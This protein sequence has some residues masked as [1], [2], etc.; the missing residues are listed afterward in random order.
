M[1]KSKP[2][3]KEKM[4]T[5]SPTLVTN[6]RDITIPN[7][8]LPP[9]LF[10]TDRFPSKRLNIY[11]SPE[12]MAFIRNVLRDMPEF[13]TIQNS[14]FGKLFDLPTRQ[15]P[16]SCKLIHSL[17]TR[18]LICLPKNTLW[19]VFGGNPFQYGLEEFGTITGL[20][21]RSFS[22]DYHPDTVKL[23][24]KPNMS[25]WKK[26]R[27]ALI[28]IV[29]GVLIAH[30]QVPCPTPCYVRM[31]EDLPS[32]LNFPW[33][34]ES[35]LK[36]ITCMRP[37]NLLP[38]K[39]DDPVKTL[40]W[41]LK[42]RTFR[43]QA[44]F[45]DLRIMD[46][47][48]GYLV[49]H[50]SINY[51]GIIRIELDS[52]LHVTP[53]IPTQSQPQPGWGMWP[54]DPKKDSV[55]NM[56]QLIT[57]QQP[58]SKPMWPGGDTSEH[59]IVKPK[60]AKKLLVKKMSCSLKES[61]K[62]NKVK[63]LQQVIKR[64]KKHSHGRHSS[65]N[66]LISRRKKQ[67]S[68][69]HCSESVTIVP[70][71]DGEQNKQEPIPMETEEFPFSQSPIISQYA[72]Q[73][74]GQAADQPPV[75]SL[76][77]H[78]SSIHVSPIHNSPIHTNKPAETTSPAQTPPLKSNDSLSG[79]A[80]HAS[81]VNAFTATASS[82]SPPG[83]NGCTVTS[84][85]PAHEAQVVD[86][87]GSFPAKRHVPSTVEIHLAK[88]LSRSP[89]IPALSLI[90][91]F[92][93]LQW[94]VFFK[95]LSASENIFHSTHST[96]EFSNNF[97]LD[98]AD[99]KKGTTTYVSRAFVI[100]FLF[101]SFFM[102]NMTHIPSSQQVE[103]LI[104]MLAARHSNLLAREYFAFMTPYLS[105]CIQ[106]KWRKFK[107]ARKKELFQW[108]QRLVD[109]V[110]LPGKKWM[111]DIHTVCTTMIWNN[112][113]WV[114]LAINLDMGYVEI[115]D[116]LPSLFANR[117]VDRFMESIVTTFPYLVKQVAKC[118]QTQFGGLKPFLWRRIPDIYTNSRSGDCGPVS[119]KFLEMHAQGDTPPHV[120]HHQPNCLRLPQAIRHGHLQDNRATLLPS[121]IPTSHSSSH[122]R[123]VYA[124]C[125]FCC[126]FKSKMTLSVARFMLLLF[127]FFGCVAWYCSMHNA[128]LC[129]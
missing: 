70:T 122:F 51:I 81:T 113:H 71:S 21:C 5:Q 15:C 9:R 86:L 32:F 18:Q 120:Q 83:V 84:K 88:E 78:T 82:N 62:P 93:V 79:F 10:A 124:F 30:K 121:S 53:I 13:E 23:E 29:D 34:R 129:L 89:L 26:I 107:A 61:L 77:I 46:L 39:S 48:D 11:S 60:A 123:V 2:K 95:T 97:L 41:Q 115:L 38:T 127:S 22:V 43:L 73:L 85:K 40:V 118:D 106:E 54:D 105:F 92:P 31:V 99:G 112:K 33:G 101:L 104:H 87:S 42:Q 64:K 91:P 98:L 47:D 110:L 52:N 44:L 4:I 45:D 125:L 25:G 114:G 56:E 28:I 19:S 27:L 17:L 100:L 102:W 7:H 117:R 12:I 37:S 63:L 74:H 24:T 66:S 96:F 116:P 128:G 3:K 126:L 58:F 14:C 68:V 1:A 36:T 69:R 119:I 111:E 80:V 75:D 6:K 103:I 57:N 90:T 108:D 35:F 67:R 72:A 76:P 59:I 55:V 20:H 49:Q 8:R 65:F 50:P 94:D 16:I 109:I